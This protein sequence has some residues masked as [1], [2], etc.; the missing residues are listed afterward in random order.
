MKQL[1]IGT[2]LFMTML[3]VNAG[4]LRA[5]TH[6]SGSQV[7][8]DKQTIEG[9]APNVRAEANSAGLGSVVFSSAS[10]GILK[11][12]SEIH[13]RDVQSYGTAEWKDSIKFVNE[14]LTGTAG[15]FTLNLQFDYIVDA[16]AVGHNTGY[17]WSQAD[18]QLSIGGKFYRWWPQDRESGW[19][20][21]DP[22]VVSMPITIEVDFVWGSAAPIHAS[23][24]A[25][26]DSVWSSTQTD[27]VANAGNSVYWGGVSNVRDASGGVVDYN[28]TSL[29]GFDYDR[30]LIPSTDVHEAATL[31]LLML[32]M[33]AIG[34]TRQKTQ[35]NQ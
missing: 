19:N 4:V 21:N 28:L 18:Y 11:A 6:I 7:L 35:R 32:G 31:A 16:S 34:R 23:L 20:L 9:A 33:V 13:G 8:S 27:C 2:V 14:A 1:V 12:S 26:C 22:Q 3:N 10:Y 24:S 25:R 17:V 15:K 29:S 30:S 5:E